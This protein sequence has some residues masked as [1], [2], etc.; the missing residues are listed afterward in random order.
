M[1]PNWRKAS[2]SGTGDA[3]VEVAGLPDGRHMVRDTKNRG[4]TVLEF[5]AP[6][7]K[8]VVTAV[9]GDQYE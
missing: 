8:T 6:E 2:F 5:S 4:G 7:W 3:C 9:R 1:E